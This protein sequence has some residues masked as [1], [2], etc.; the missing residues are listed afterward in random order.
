MLKSL[1]LAVAGTAI[2]TA[3]PGGEEI[4]RKSID[5]QGGAEHIKAVKTLQ[6]TGKAFIGGKIE[7]PVIYRAKRPLR[8]RTELQ[9]QGHSMTEGFDGTVKWISDGATP[10]KAPE[11][12]A[13]SALDAAD[14]IGSPLFNYKEKGNTVEFVGKEDTDGQACFKFKVK[15]KS[16]NTAFVYVDQKSYLTFKTIT[17]AGDLEAVSKLNDYR[18]VDN[19]LIPFANAIR[20]NGQDVMLMKYDKAEVNVPMDDALFSMPAKK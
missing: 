6:L 8:Y 3:Q 18:K 1:L 2:L 5:A 16:G 19:I 4:I 12:G 15:L 17:R 9:I 14:P 7:A 10:A 13:K 11:E 20:I